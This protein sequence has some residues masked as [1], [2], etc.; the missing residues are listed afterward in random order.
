MQAG[1]SHSVIKASASAEQEAAGGDEERQSGGE[2]W[3]VA[4]PLGGAAAGGRSWPVLQLD[5]QNGRQANLPVLE[6][7]RHQPALCNRA[8][9]YIAR[10]GGIGTAT[11]AA[12]QFDLTHS[13]VTCLALRCLQASM[14]RSG[15]IAGSESS[16]ATM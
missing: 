4:E 13:K 16:G 1:P 9:E 14:A 6:S 15:G 11:H 3:E 2:T 5:W 8:G 7:C 10:C 12:Q